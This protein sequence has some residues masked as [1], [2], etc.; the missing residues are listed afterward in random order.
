VRK[1][2]VNNFLSD[3]TYLVVKL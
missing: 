3:Y 2:T 1:V